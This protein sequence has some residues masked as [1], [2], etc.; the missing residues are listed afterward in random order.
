M[1][2]SYSAAVR[3]AITNSPV[4]LPKEQVLFIKEDHLPTH[5]LTGTAPKG[6]VSK[7]GKKINLIETKPGS[8]PQKL[9]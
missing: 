6:V 7:G 3:G 4:M 9:L 1:H 2:P 5:V 8:R